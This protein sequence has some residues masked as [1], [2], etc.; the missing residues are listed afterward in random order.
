MNDDDKDNNNNNNNNNNPRT[1]FIVLSSWPLKVI[2]RVHSVHLM[3][4]AQRTSG[5]RPSDQATRLGLWWHWCH[6]DD[7]DDINDDVMMRGQALLVLRSFNM[8]KSSMTLSSFSEF[9]LLRDVPP[10]DE[11]PLYHTH[12]SHIYTYV[13]YIYTRDIYTHTWQTYVH[14]LQLQLSPSPPSS[15]AAI[16]SGMET[17]QYR[18]IQIVLENADRGHVTK[19]GNFPNSRWRT[20]AILKT[21]FGV[22]IILATN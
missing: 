12:T 3:N 9:C 5:R 19:N 17:L 16:E 2:A 18:L 6:D 8:S 7:K 14:V 22:Y 20:A 15:L 10:L 11:P 1:I 4:A 13:T 21:V